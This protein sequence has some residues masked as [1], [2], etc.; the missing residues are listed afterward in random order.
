MRSFNVRDD[1]ATTARNTSRRS[2]VVKARSSSSIFPA[3]AHSRT[4]G[5]ACRATTRICAP[6]S[7]RPS[8][9]GSPTFPAPTTR[10]RFPCNFKNMGNRLVT[11][12]SRGLRQIL[13][14]I[15]GHCRN[16]FPGK[17]LAQLRVAVARKEATQILSGFA[18]GEIA[19]KKPL[20]RV[21]NVRRRAAV[22]DRPR[23]CLMQAECSA[24]AEIIGVDQ[25]VVDLDLFPLNADVGDPVLTATVWAAC[26]MQLQMLIESGQA[27]LQ[28]LYQPTREALGFG[29]GELAELGAAAGNRSTRE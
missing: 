21:R 22:A 6:V 28:F 13:R 8:I 18:L 24:N 7:S 19:A 23:R 9:F 4:A 27:L 16:H 20:Q 17:K 15:A 5:L 11:D 14:Q 25:A 10:H 26:Y 29:D 2:S 12:S 1:V 3:R